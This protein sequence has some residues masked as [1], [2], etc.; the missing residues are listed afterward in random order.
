LRNHGGKIPEQKRIRPPVA[1]S[2]RLS[3]TR[4]AV[5]STPRGGGHLPRPG[6]PIA[7]HQSKNIIAGEFAERSW[8]ED[9]GVVI[10]SAWR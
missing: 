8:G 2:V 6:V 9:A 4:G 10:G 5:T 3:F 7:H 1:G